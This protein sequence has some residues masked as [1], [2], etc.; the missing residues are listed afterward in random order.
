M[1]CEKCGHEP[2]TTNEKLRGLFAARVGMPARVNRR[3][4]D[5]STVE[6]AT[7][8]HAAGRTAEA[9]GLLA[10]DTVDPSRACPEFR[11]P[12]G[13]ADPRPTAQNVVDALRAIEDITG[14]EPERFDEATGPMGGAA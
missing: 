13:F 3:S 6:L 11:R 4:P 8:I 1:I 9:L 7:E 10:E 12:V 5:A 2:E 14:E